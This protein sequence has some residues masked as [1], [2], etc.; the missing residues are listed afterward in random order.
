MTRSL[1]S[2][3]VA[4]INAGVRPDI[5]RWVVDLLGSIPRA[6]LPRPEVETAR[7]YTLVR[8]RA[9]EKELTLALGQPGFAYWSRLLPDGSRD[10]GRLDALPAQDLE[11]LFDWLLDDVVVRA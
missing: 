5:A 3:G 1:V 10:R 11:R 2:A 4:L 8:F 6:Y 7:G 9:G